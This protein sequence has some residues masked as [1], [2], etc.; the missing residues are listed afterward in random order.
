MVSHSSLWK[1]ERK[2]K[3]ER[4]GRQGQI[5]Y[6]LCLVVPKANAM[7]WQ[8]VYIKN[9]TITPDATI[10][11]SALFSSFRFQVPPMPR[12]SPP[13]PQRYRNMT[14]K[15]I[16]CKEREKSHMSYRILS[17]FNS[18]TIIA[19]KWPIPV[20][21][22]PAAHSAHTRSGQCVLR[23]VWV[24][25]ALIRPPYL[26]TAQPVFRDCSTISGILP[27][28]YVCRVFFYETYQLQSLDEYGA[29]CFYRYHSADIIVDILQLG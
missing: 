4:L 3:I 12:N 23:S 14:T 13:S 29:N 26:A 9:P 27:Y 15:L 1:E 21:P 18:Y 2:I 22:H 19:R 20:E 28:I 17:C 8:P 16:S 24:M 11:A 25:F 6:P 7:V 5:A 10:S